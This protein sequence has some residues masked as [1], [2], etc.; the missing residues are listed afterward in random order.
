MAN[1]GDNSK[2]LR[3]SIDWSISQLKTPRKNRL[4]AIKQYVGNHYS[5]HGSEFPVPTNFIESIIA[6]FMQQLAANAPRCIFT[7]EVNHLK[8]WAYTT[9][10]ELNK[11]PAEIGLD[12]TIRRFVL[13]AMF[14]YGVIKVG[15]ARSGMVM[16]GHDVGQPFADL[17]SIDDYFCDM[18]AKSRIEIQ[19]E[20]NDYWMS[21]DEARELWGNKIEPDQYT[22]VGEQGEVDASSVSSE[23]GAELFMDKVHLRDVWIP[24]TNKLETYRI[25]TGQ[26]FSMIDWDGP[27]G[28]PYHMLGFSEVPGNL[29]PLPPVAVWRDLHELGN[30]L[31]RKLARQADEKKMFAA[32]HGGSDDDKQSIVKVQDGEGVKV[33]AAKV[34]TVIVGGIDAPTLAFYLQIKELSNYFS[35]NPDALGGLGRQSE[36]VGQD[37]MIKQGASA[38]LEF[39]RKRTLDAVKGVFEALAWYRWTDPVRK[40]KINKRIKGSSYVVSSV[41]SDETREGDWLDYNFELDVYSMQENSPSATL[42]KI[43]AYLERVVYPALPIMQQQGI[44]IDF[45]L[46]NE[47]SAKLSNVPEINDILIFGEPNQGLPEHGSSEP[48]RMPSNTT[49]TYERIGRSGATDSGKADVMSRLL[50]GGKV[51]PSEGAKIG[52]V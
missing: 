44:S 23:E 50:M 47:L 22:L 1:I 40:S 35:G 8:P 51:Q 14:G 18:S 42:S 2:K 28:G 41:W 11:I 52:G 15:M 46:L 24:D 7:T 27:D 16:L 49:R 13:E 20:G 31:F 21:V 39:M 38:R 36:T 45:E 32:L 9:E 34:D 30:L 12:E 26:T 4:D 19:Y 29:M 3:A 43:I 17:V 37:E 48:V 10:I 5:D 6:V 33:G 25:K